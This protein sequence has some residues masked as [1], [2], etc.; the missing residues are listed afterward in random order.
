MVGDVCFRILKL[1]NSSCKISNLG[2][3]SFRM[4][5]MSWGEVT[6]FLGFLSIVV[7]DADDA[8]KRDDDGVLSLFR[9]S[10]PNGLLIWNGKI[11]K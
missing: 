4:S 11:Y 9:K 6:L 1:G 10:D 3:A 2:D 8:I 7:R 5:K